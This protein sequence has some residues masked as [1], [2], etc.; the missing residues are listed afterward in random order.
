RKAERQRHGRPLFQLL[1]QAEQHDVVAARTEFDRLARRNLQPELELAHLHHALFVL[2]AF[3]NF[4]TLRDGGRTS[5]QR[6]V[7]DP[8]ILDREVDGSDAHIP[9]RRP[10]PRIVDRDIS[11]L[12]FACVAGK[13]SGEDCRAAKHYSEHG[14][15][16][17]WELYSYMRKP[18]RQ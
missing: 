18:Q 1:L 4:N 14:S 3:V 17:D 6:V 10:R 8:V 15:F 12:E 9:R 7:V 16:T 5:P 11:L 13:G 2:K